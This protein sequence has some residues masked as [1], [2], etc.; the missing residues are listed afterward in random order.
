MSTKHFLKPCHRSPL[1]G[2]LNSTGR[3]GLKRLR[4]AWPLHRSPRG[5]GG[6]GWP[7][8]GSG[9][10]AV[11]KHAVA[12]PPHLRPLVIFFLAGCGRGVFLYYLKDRKLGVPKSRIWV[13]R[14]PP[15]SPQPAPE[16]GAVRPADCKCAGERAALWPGSPPAFRQALKRDWLGSAGQRLLPPLQLGH[17]VPCFCLARTNRASRVGSGT[18]P[19]SGLSLFFLSLL[20]RV[21]PGAG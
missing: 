10:P 15:G 5:Q 12:C 8:L 17:L 3:G 9:Q 6:V 18:L 2:S 13:C 14:R 21:L 4:E 19:A 11:Q 1:S 16:R 20:P 7:G